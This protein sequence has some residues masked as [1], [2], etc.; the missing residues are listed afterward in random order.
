MAD[1]RSCG[2][3]GNPLDSRNR[4]ITI[5]LPFT[6]H[7][8]RDSASPAVPQRPSP[9]G[10]PAIAFRTRAASTLLG[11]HD[12]RSGSG[13]CGYIPGRTCRLRFVKSDLSRRSPVV[14][15]SVMLEVPFVRVLVTVVLGDDSRSPGPPPSA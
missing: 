10:R 1:P 4:R 7:P 13:P 9:L 11:P 15:Y 12:S 3:A 2:I 5:L 8:R 14:G 6:T